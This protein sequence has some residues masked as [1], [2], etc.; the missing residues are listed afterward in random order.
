MHAP[1]WNTMQ[2]YMRYKYQTCEHLGSAQK[3]AQTE[4]D[5]Y[6]YSVSVSTST[7]AGDESQ[8]QSA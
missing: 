8:E 2:L 7:L 4:S 1:L 6:L 3:R 5:V